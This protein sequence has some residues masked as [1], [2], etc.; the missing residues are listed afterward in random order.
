MLQALKPL[1]ALRLVVTA[2][3][4]GDI[5]TARLGRER[6]R[7][8]LQPLKTQ[9]VTLN[10]PQALLGYYGTHLFRLRFSSRYGAETETDPRTLGS[11]VRLI[12]VDE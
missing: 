11:F 2:G 4:A 8:V 5:V 1:R 12:L 3:P 6:R 7:L 9:E 10:E